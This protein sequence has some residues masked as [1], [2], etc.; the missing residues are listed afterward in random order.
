MSEQHFRIEERIHKFYGVQSPNGNTPDLSP[1]GAA[2][3]YS[4]EHS[5]R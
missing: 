1:L 3:I 2:G 4:R 5:P